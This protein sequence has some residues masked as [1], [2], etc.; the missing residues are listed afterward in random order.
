MIQG[1][2]INKLYSNVCLRSRVSHLPLARAVV[3]TMNTNPGWNIKLIF[4]F[5]AAKC[6][7][8]NSWW[9]MTPGE[10]TSLKP[11]DDEE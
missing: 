7:Y 1:D 5:I 8:A 2:V 6:F 3:K 10:M 4:S 11:R 9:S